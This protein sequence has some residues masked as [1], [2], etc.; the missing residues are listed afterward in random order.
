MGLRSNYYFYQKKPMKA[1]IFAAGKGTRLQPLTNTVPK[2]L[3][4]VKGVTLLEHVIKHLKSH[5]VVDV[6]I[7]IHYLGEM[8]MEFIDAHSNFGINI[9]FSDER[10]E[11]LE[12][13]GGLKKASAFFTNGQDFIAYNTDILSDIDLS[14]MMRYHK[15]EKSL[16]T[17]AVRERFTSRYFLFDEDNT[18]KGWKNDNT[19]EI[20]TIGKTDKALRALAFSGIHI[21]NPKIFEL[22]EEEGPFSISPVYL[23]LAKN[24]KIKAFEHTSGQWFDIGKHDTLTAAEKLFKFYY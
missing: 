15:Q 18:L 24:H 13:G 11:L 21:I 10:D 2:A 23:R 4:K 17:L 19:G 8:I 1:I 12:T 5:G 16:V 22:I 7:N 14:Q 9:T 20:V 3:V 6:I